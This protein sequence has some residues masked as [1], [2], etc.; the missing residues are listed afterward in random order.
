LVDGPEVTFESSLSGSNLSRIQKNVESFVPASPKGEKPK[1]EMK[2][3]IGLFKVTNGKVN[4]SLTALSGKSL[5]V[6][7]PDIELRDIGRKSNGATVGEA[8]KQMFGAVTGAATRA[9]AGS[10]N[11]LKGG[12]EQLE[13]AGKA[14]TGLVKGLFSKKK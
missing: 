10:G 12:K 11:L 5:S 3:E 7:L 8:A 1:K 9:V 4:L 13:N 2:V 6:P 14:A